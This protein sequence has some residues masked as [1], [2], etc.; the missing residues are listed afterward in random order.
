[1]VHFPPPTHLINA[2]LVFP[3]PRSSSLSPDTDVLILPLIKAADRLE[4]NGRAFPSCF[5]LRRVFHLN[6][7]VLQHTTAVLES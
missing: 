7:L 6:T 4:N 3:P 2:S 5:F 1:M